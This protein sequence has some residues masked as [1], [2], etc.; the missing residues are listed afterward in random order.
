ME[1][2]NS[3]FEQLKTECLDLC[4]DCIAEVNREVLHVDTSTVTANREFSTK[5]TVRKELLANTVAESF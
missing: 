4:N 5:S 3:H 1:L 2:P